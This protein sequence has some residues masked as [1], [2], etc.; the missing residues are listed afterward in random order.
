MIDHRAP[1]EL[2]GAECC[3]KT[4]RCTA[5]FLR[6]SPW[7]SHSIPVCRIHKKPSALERLIWLSESVRLSDV[8]K[9]DLKMLLATFTSLQRFIKASNKIWPERLA[10]YGLRLSTKAMEERR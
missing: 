7:A 6:R 4:C 3:W 2:D 8:E 5:E 9:Q 1:S 10:F